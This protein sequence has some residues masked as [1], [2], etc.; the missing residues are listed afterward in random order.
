MSD[1]L[2]RRAF[3]DAVSKAS[4]PMNVTGASELASS[5]GSAYALK[6][7]RLAGYTKGYVSALR[8]VQ[9]LKSEIERLRQMKTAIPEDKH[10][11]TIEYLLATSE[12][13]TKSADIM[14]RMRI[15]D[16]PP[17]DG[18]EPLRAAEHQKP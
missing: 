4:L 15:P 16:N 12:V 7:E 1:E 13:L 8:R 6:K 14:I 2:Q 17:N 9:A 18:T 11:T 5:D 3:V 10:D